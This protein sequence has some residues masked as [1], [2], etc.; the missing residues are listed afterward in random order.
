MRPMRRS[1]GL[2]AAALAVILLAG[3]ANGDVGGAGSRSTATTD[4]PPDA[5]AGPDDVGTAAT[6]GLRVIS[7]NICG[8]ASCD[9]RGATAPLSSVTT[10]IDDFQPHLFML[11]E[12]CWS[13]YQF[14]AAHEFSSGPYQMGFTVMIHNY[15]GCG[16]AD[17]SVNEDEDPNNDNKQCWTGQLLAAK[18]TISN[19]DE[20]P[21]GGERHQVNKDG[22]P[23]IP[24]RKFNALCYDVALAGFTRTVK[25]CSVHM[26]AFADPAGE[27]KRARTAQTAR[28]ASDLDGDIAAGKIVVVGGDF[29]SVPTDPAMNA[30][31]RLDTNVE[32]AWGRFYEADQDDKT[33]YNSAYCS[34]TAAACRSGAKTIGVSSKLDYIFYSET[35]DA[36]SVS[37]LPIDESMSDHWFYRGLANVRAS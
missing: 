17:C 18:G 26:R 16:V 7:H 30:F 1:V 13:Q 10:L 32:N 31:Y 36:T 4:A 24:P 29:N 27:S 6:V 33:Y 25:G 37:G 23:V 3:P 5:P 8:G 22:N 19:R 2:L 20:I 28:L 11:Q 35:T 14:L 34:Q 21:L 9:N 12:V 15:T